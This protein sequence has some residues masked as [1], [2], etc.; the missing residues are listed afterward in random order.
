VAA[1]PTCHQQY[2][3]W[4]HGPAKAPYAKLKAGLKSLQ[5]EGNAEDLPGMTAALKRT[6][7]AA[8]V[9]AAA[10]LPK[11][12]DPKGY[13]GEL[14]ARIRAAGDNARSASGLGGILLAL[15]PL[16]SVEGI[17]MKLER[18]LDRTVGKKR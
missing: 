13:Y 7:Q 14:L 5:A 9:M 1:A 6:G 18:E 3:T 17:S 15:A 4:K 11:C 10:P 8:R 2:E 12:S 16:K